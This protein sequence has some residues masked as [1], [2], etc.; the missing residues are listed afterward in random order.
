MSSTSSHCAWNASKSKFLVSVAA[1]AMLAACSADADRFTS[2]ASDADPVYTASVPNRVTA[3]NVGTEDEVSSKPL[4]GA[5]AQPPSYDY[6]NSYRSTQYRQPAVTAAALILAAWS[7][8]VP[9]W[10]TAWSSAATGGR[11]TW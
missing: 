8:P 6:S 10:V 4:T 7:T 2:N 5:S 3:A 1:A 11:P 9:G